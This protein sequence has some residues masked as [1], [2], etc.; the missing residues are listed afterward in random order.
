[1]NN[2]TS[3]FKAY[4]QDT[5]KVSKLTTKN[6]LSDLRFFTSWLSDSNTLNLDLISSIDKKTLLNY[7]QFLLSKKSAKST[8][9]RRLA[10]LR[11][12]CQF[13]FVNNLLA[14][15]YAQTISGLPE[16]K[17]TDK[18]IHDLV[19]KFGNYLKNQRSSRNTIKNYTADVKKYLDFAIDQ[20]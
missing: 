14:K 15:N 12:F 10:S 9:N 20:K 19:S 6:Y 11:V 17:P 1:M 18:K 8:T 2:F 4:L 16:V 13:C 3:L 7:K 5:R